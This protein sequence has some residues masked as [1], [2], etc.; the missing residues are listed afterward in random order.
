[1]D[2]GQLVLLAA[3]DE[4]IEGRHTDYMAG[5]QKSKQSY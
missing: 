2:D 3:V 1:M 4:P 5:H